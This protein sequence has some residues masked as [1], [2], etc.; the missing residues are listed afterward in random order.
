MTLLGHLRLADPARLALATEDARLS[1]GE[2][3][4][5]AGALREALAG[6]RGA[7][8]FLNLADPMAAVLALAALDGLAGALVLSSPALDAEDVTVLAAQAGA[9]AILSERADLG[10]DL[11][12]LADAAT[13]AGLALPRR[14]IARSDW[15]M[16]TSGTTGQPKLVAHGLESLTRTTR[17]DQDRGRGQV[18]GLL[19]DYSRFAGLQ[20]LL[21]GLLSGAALAL[22]AV[23]LPLEARLAFLVRAGVT[24]L[25]ATPTLWRKM[26]MTPGSEALALAQI[27]L[28]G[29]IA[30]DA[31]LAALARRWPAARISH[32]F[33][34]TEAG[35]G[36]SVTDGRA[37][38]PG[39]YL[40]APPQGIG[41]R[42]TEGRLFIRNDLVGPDYL[43]GQGAL[44]QGGW[45]DTGDA[46]RV[47]GGRVL[48][49][50]RSNGV[51]NVGGDKVHPEEVEAAI[52][53]HPGVGMARVYGRRNPIVGA[54]VA[55]DI[56]PAAGISDPKA[57]QAEL[58]SFLAGRLARHQV[59]A[60]IRMVDSFETNAA[61]KLTRGKE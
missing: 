4:A 36:F 6:L 55:A 24:H 7:R 19:Y 13:L 2:L 30:D 10:T 54:L 33:A 1:Y 50:G 41:L 38:F 37:G 22:P 49:Q 15:V 58:K 32:V 51:I 26:L 20:V 60:L 12:V 57:L 44:A 18:W 28:G 16:T 34:S 8:L 45:V 9:D 14:D 3:T 31:V 42:V 53:A 39:T 17:R 25:S 43:G 23:S 5:R 27:T 21:Q 29:E 52:L 48:F 56:L 35:V 11:P 47:V 46:V 59:P 40:D 61:G